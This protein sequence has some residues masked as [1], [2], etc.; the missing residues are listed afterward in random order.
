M[1]MVGIFYPVGAALFWSIAVIL[2]RKSGDKM[3]PLS[4]N[5]F[6][7]LVALVLLLPTLLVMQIPFFPDCPAS[8][9]WLLSLSGI[10]GITLADSFFFAS[11]VR[12]GAGLSSIVACL[13]LPTIIVLSY[14]F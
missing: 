2:F 4:L 11:L 14:F 13:Y 8:D 6:C 7:C 1:I 12:L 5:F 9:W 3:S 10:L